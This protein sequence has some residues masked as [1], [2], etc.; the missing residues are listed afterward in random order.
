MTLVDT[1][2]VGGAERMAATI[3]EGLDRERFEPMVCETRDTSNAQLAE[4]LEAAG[5]P[6][7]RLHRTRRSAI[8]K[9]G[10][11]VRELRRRQV[12]VLHSHKFGSNV[13][14]TTL[15]RLARVPVIV[16]HE[17]GSERDRLHH[18]IDRLIIGRGVDAF[19]TVSEA[20][21]AHVVDVERLR[22]EKVRLIRNGI[23]ALPP[24]TSDLRAELELPQDAP[25]IGTL[26]VLRPEKALDVLLDAV[27]LLA[28]RVPGLRVLIAGMGP[29]EAGLRALVGQHGLQDTVRFIGFRRDVANVLAAL[30][31][32]VFCSDRE[33]MPLAVI[34][35]MAAG[36][37]IVASE[38]EGISEL[39]TDG[40]EGL[41]VRRR[42]PQAL[43]N[44]VARLLADDA[45]RD[46]LGSR[47]RQRQQHD[48]DLGGTVRAFEDLY[49]ELFANR[50]R[51]RQTRL[52]M[53]L[54]A[55]S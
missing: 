15:G 45:L 39:M 5:I 44:A 7:L 16:A 27:A 30:D 17:H 41:L 50:R 6:I 33:A 29:E 23:A 13:W 43:A 10:P 34:E 19:V 55:T 11:L 14:A 40:V 48:L 47:A 46:E 38:Y 9:W 22:P 8:W 28:P 37:A 52:A 20:E 53:P 26:A 4:S 35:A 54:S 32:A 18:A 2:H 36:R 3:T 31:V 49:D 25:L 51:G 42:D 21:R 12:H 1:L 24:V